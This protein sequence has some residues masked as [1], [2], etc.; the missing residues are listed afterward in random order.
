M[1]GTVGVDVGGTFT[2][3]LAVEEGRLRVYKR[4]STPHDPAEAV[5]QG[6]REMGATPDEVVHGST[7][8]TNTVLERSGARTALITT[9]GF[10]DVLEIGRQT[11]ANL[12]GLAPRRTPPLVERALR[13]E[14]AERVAADGTVLKPLLAGEVAR[15]VAEVEALQVDSVAVC[16]LFSFL[17]P[18]HERLITAA[19]RAKGISATASH[20]VLPEYREYERASTTVLNA[21]LAP[22]VAR[23]LT[24]LEEAL[25]QAGVR[26]L[27]IMQ[28]DG[29]SLGPAATAKRA[30]RMVLSGPA[31]GVAG[32]FAVAKETGFDQVIT[33]DMGGT[34]TDVSLCPGRILERF[35]LEVSGLPLRVP[36]VDVNTVG[37]GG[38]SIARLDTG[39]A[40]RVGP[41]SARADPGPACYGVGS[42]PTVTDAQV[43]LGRLQPEHFLGG[44]MPLYPE[45]ALAALI[46]LGGD[47]VANAAAI[48]RVANANMERAIRVISVER[49]YDPRGFALVAFGG[50]GPLHA[51]DLAESLGIGRVLVPRYPGV[52]SA[53][54][55]AAAD[56]SRDYLRPFMGRLDAQDRNQAGAAM[57][58][59]NALLAEA[60]AQGRAELLSEGLPEATLRGERWLTMRYVGQSYELPMPVVDGQAATVVEAFHALHER[61]YGHAD[62]QRPVEA[63][64]VR[65]RVIAPGVE[66][67]LAPQPPT[68][69]PLSRALVG[70]T[71]TWFGDWEETPV[72]DRERLGPGHRF[73]GPAIVVQMDSTTVV[74]PGWSATVQPGEAM[75]LEREERPG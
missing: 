3:F 42:V 44:R 31:G 38:G 16:L 20:E 12:Y 49:G 66:L 2:D 17:F 68:E 65:A 18:E 9:Q 22:V 70:R 14:V 36:S 54:G 64:S 53:L 1:P 10:R 43:A 60:E 15:V 55:M 47:P 6:L 5:L 74:P 39:G 13:L 75:L 52:L 32:A 35:E 48:V 41:E 21:Y 51:C 23:Y 4:L 57:E 11:R 8:A 24:R 7:V 28:S 58:Q 40:L 19:L 59:I 29:T 71:H 25:A 46:G 34:S 62:R 50:A 45:R 33:F 69:E 72:Y 67:R 63:V 26:R 73:A 27:R 56:S 37:A 61:T 30:V